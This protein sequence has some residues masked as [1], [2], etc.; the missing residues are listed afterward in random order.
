MRVKSHRKT[1]R[2]CLAKSCFEIVAKVVAKFSNFQE[3]FKQLFGRLFQKNRKENVEV[4][5]G[6]CDFEILTPESNS[7]LGCAVDVS[8]RL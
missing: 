4:S 7:I 8:R 6:L 3:I 5:D 1:D 2:V